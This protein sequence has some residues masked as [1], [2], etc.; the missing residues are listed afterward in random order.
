MQGL[1]LSAENVA[2]VVTAHPPVLTYGVE[3]RL[4]PLVDFLAA[5]GLPSE[6]LA[7]AFVRRP[8]LL[9]LSVQAQ[10]VRKGGLPGGGLMGCF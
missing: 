2:A 8:T 3:G 1:G 6:G 10:L 9:G 7:A 5:R 4:R